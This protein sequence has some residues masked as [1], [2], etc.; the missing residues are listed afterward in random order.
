MREM[1]DQVLL[2]ADAIAGRIGELADEITTD[3][4]ASG[5]D[6][7]NV[8]L[9]P[10]MTG[11]LMFVAD[12]VRQLPVPMRI[13][14]VSV[15]AYPGRAT[16]SVG[17]T[18]EGD[19]PDAE[20]LRGHHVLIIDDILDS[21]S[22]LDTLIREFKPF[23]P[24]SLRSCVLLAKEGRDRP[25]EADYVGFTIPDRFVV[26]Y[27]LDYDGLYRNLPEIATL[28]PAALESGS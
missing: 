12:L 16:T 1:I 20:V 27:G 19:L 5:D 21:G 7:L 25:V 9:I 28:D 4:N 6:P 23:E 10:V 17:A 24:A 2:D 13:E 11:S 26:G 3:L 18:L 14:V 15:T 22:T 8:T